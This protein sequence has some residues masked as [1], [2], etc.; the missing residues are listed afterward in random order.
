MH[1]HRLQTKGTRDR[2]PCRQINNQTMSSMFDSPVHG[3]GGDCN[4]SAFGDFDNDPDSPHVFSMTQHARKL[5]IDVT[6][7]SSPTRPS[8]AAKQQPPPPPPANANDPPQTSTPKFKTKENSVPTPPTGLRR[9]KSAALKNRPKQLFKASSVHHSDA[10]TTTTKRGIYK[11]MEELKTLL[12][13]RSSR[14]P[15]SLSPSY[16]T[17]VA[18]KSAPT[19]TSGTTSTNEQSMDVFFDATSNTE[20]IGWTS[21][22]DKNVIT[23][24]AVASNSQTAASVSIV[25]H[26]SKSLQDEFLNDSDFDMVLIKTS[27]DVEKKLLDE[28][29]AAAEAVS[30]AAEKLKPTAQNNLLLDNFLEQDSFDDLFS[31]K[32]LDQLIAQSQQSPAVVG[33]GRSRVSLE[34]HKSM[35]TTTT[36]SRERFQQQRR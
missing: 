36:M 26:L 14:W 20:S 2:T 13:G 18:S 17:A 11:F 7:A 6:W 35:P 12:P 16:H 10:P 28:Q 3:G 30:A 8:Q 9:S 4:T 21:S 31:S 25:D 22:C 33:A 1:F 23:D 5:G 27:Q 24:G 29:L 15:A 32:E 34:R 19:T